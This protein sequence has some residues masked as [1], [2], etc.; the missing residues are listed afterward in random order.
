MRRLRLLWA[1]AIFAVSLTLRSLDM[2]LCDK[3]LIE[4]RKVGTHF[5]WHVLNALALFLL[6]RAS[7]EG[8]P[9]SV[10][11]AEAEVAKAKR[12]RNCPPS[13]SATEAGRKGCAGERRGGKGGRGAQEE[14]ERKSFFPA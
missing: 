13:A 4:G 6:L 5:A 1:A 7:L 11:R 12:R 14:G 3:V 10:T 8:G 2:A 9:L